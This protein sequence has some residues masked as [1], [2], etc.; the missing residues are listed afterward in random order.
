[1]LTEK[2]I[3][4]YNAIMKIGLLYITALALL[5]A[6]CPSQLPEP[7]NLQFSCNTQDDCHKP[8]SCIHHLCQLATTDAAWTDL[9]KTDR[10]RPDT[11]FADASLDDRTLADRTQ[12]DRASLDI[13]DSAIVDSDVADTDLPDS[14]IQDSSIQ[15]SSILDSTV[16]DSTVSDST[17]SDSTVS[18]NNIPDNAIADQTNQDTNSADLAL[19]DAACASGEHDGGGG[20]CVPTGTCFSGFHDGGDGRCVA[21]GTCSSGFSLQNWFRDQDGDGYGLES[22]SIMACSQPDGYVNRAGD[23][24]D[25]PDQDPACGG[26][27]GRNCH[28]DQNDL[29]D[30][31]DNDCDADI[32]EDSSTP[33]PNIQD[34]LIT[35]TTDPAQVIV[36]WTQATVCGPESI[37]VL[38]CQNAFASGPTDSGCTPITPDANGFTDSDV[39]AGQSYYY[40]IYTYRAALGYSDQRSLQVL[41]GRSSVS[42]EKI[43]PL[44]GI[45]IDGFDNDLAWATS[46]K[47]DFSFSQHDGESAGQD[48]NILGYVRL[49]YDDDNFYFFIHVEDRFL[50]VDSGA[51]VWKDDGVELF[52]DMNFDRHSLPDSNDFHIILSPKPDDDYYEK[53]TGNDW[54]NTWSP[55]MT[56]SER[57]DGS[58]NNN[59][60]VDSFW[61]IEL[62]IPFSELGI[63]SLAPG[64]TIGFT[65]WI[66]ED[67]TQDHNQQHYYPWTVGTLSTDSST[68]GLCSF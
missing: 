41:V 27:P 28:P 13:A 54:D 7:A 59:N 61:N 19:P 44:S 39:I 10:D 66:N 37:I 24:A 49:A 11:F 45:A 58:F 53:G 36:S 6:A 67:D 14:G 29:C 48:P 60:D 20:N 12:A 46:T 23:C 18:D 34:L 56:R 51:T 43:D 64:Q 32:D 42:P 21:E 35:S 62:A 17:V 25:L 2:S 65:F 55:N 50:W 16:S 33:I 26:Q 47:I 1:M 68:W 38:R 15:D 40:G 8:Q 3:K 5:L 9:A 57:V 4:C 52:F 63:S 31:I 22:D 30:A